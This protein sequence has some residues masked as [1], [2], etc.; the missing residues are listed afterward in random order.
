[1]GIIHNNMMAALEQANH[2]LDHTFAEPLLLIR[3]AE[4]GC[5]HP[6]NAS[7]GQEYCEQVRDHPVSW[8]FY[9]HRWYA[10]MPGEK[11]EQA[12]YKALLPL[13]NIPR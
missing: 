10:A 9:F 11:P 12:D 2:H 1:M 8:R 13:N 5:A 3:R 4:P 7:A 6:E